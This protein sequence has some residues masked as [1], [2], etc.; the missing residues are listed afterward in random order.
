M[1]SDIIV[2]ICIALIIPQR[3]CMDPPRTRLVMR[4]PPETILVNLV[5]KS[6]YSCRASAVEISETIGGRL[7]ETSGIPP[8]KVSGDIFFPEFDTN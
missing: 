7:I 4:F 3:Y 1:T 2:I 5:T 8:S 6:I